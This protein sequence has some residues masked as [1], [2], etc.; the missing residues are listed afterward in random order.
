[1]A[2]QANTLPR[3]SR[4]VREDNLAVFAESESEPEDIH[5][6]FSSSS[7]S[8][9]DDDEG[10]Y[11]SD[12]QRI[13]G[14]D[15]YAPLWCPT[16]NKRVGPMFCENLEKDPLAFFMLFF[17]QELFE[18]MAYETNEYATI[19]LDSPVDLPPKSRFQYW[20]DTTAD[21]MK[22]Y[23][24]LQ[25]Y[26]GL[27]DKPAIKDYWATGDYDNTT[28]FCEVMSRNRYELL[29]WFMHFNDNNKQVSK[30][31]PG[32]DPLYKIRPMLDMMRPRLKYYYTPE[33]ELAIDES[34]QKFK[35]RLYFKQYMPNK[36]TKWGIKLWSLCESKS[37]YLLDFDIYTGKDTGAD[38]EHGLGHNVVCKL[39][40][41]TIL[42]LVITSVL[43]T[44]A[45]ALHYSMT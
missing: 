20:E 30:G 9:E 10:H 16:Y 24:G 44:F 2:D 22:A 42:T 45:Q 15:N 18:L 26:M 5:R 4:L 3:R 13:D 43:T 1:M 23:V 29:S 17:P 25:I 36:P 34:M 21:E 37:G 7:D 38:A 27:T 12:W 14:N 31:E 8:D 33:R 35:G 6:S 11:F 19:C 39:L 40:G 28:R 41:D 32:Y